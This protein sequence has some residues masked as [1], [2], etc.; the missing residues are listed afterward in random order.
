MRGLQ[1]ANRDAEYPPRRTAWLA[2]CFGK[3]PDV[4]G[5]VCL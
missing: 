1:N 5:W 2:V 3:L 4:A